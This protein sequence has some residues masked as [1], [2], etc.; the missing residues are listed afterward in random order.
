MG[1]AE[2][3]GFGRCHDV[4]SRARWNGRAV[5]R[6]L[7]AQVLDAFLPTSENSIGP[8]IAGGCQL[9]FV[10]LSPELADL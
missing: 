8:L 5:A 7:L 10:E 3:P 6:T 9:L 2:R 4:L 1:L